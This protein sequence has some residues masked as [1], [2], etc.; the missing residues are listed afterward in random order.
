MGLPG[1]ELD[2]T[3][4]SRDRAKPEDERTPMCG[5]PYHSCDGYIARLI[6]KGYKVAI[7]VSAGIVR[8]PLSSCRQRGAGSVDFPSCSTLDRRRVV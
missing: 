1:G 6:S 5:V 8:H 4:T 7:L 2:L 3:L